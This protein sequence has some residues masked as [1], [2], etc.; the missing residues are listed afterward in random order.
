[1]DHHRSDGPDPLRPLTQLGHLAN[2]VSTHVQPAEMGNQAINSLALISARRTTEANDVLTLLLATHLYCALQA[3]DLRAMEF[4][5][6]AQF[7]PLV[8]DLLQEHFKS[9]ATP[10][11]EVKVRKA[12]EKRLQQNNSYDLEQRWHDTFSVAMGTVVETLG[13]QDVSLASLNAWK[14]ACAEKAIAITRSVRDSFWTTPSAQSP[15]LK[16][17]SPRT[18]L[19]YSFVREE[20]G[21]KARRGDVYLGKQEP[22]VG[23]NVSRIYEAIKTGKIAPVLVKMLA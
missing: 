19:M 2:P 1:M 23:S 7:Q 5:H 3:V 13:G 18:R 9:L 16:Y 10:E 22:M 15:T 12:I 21:V 14:V 4:E 6:T 17:L 11:L 20:V 8:S